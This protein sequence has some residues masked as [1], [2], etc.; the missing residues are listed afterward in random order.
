MDIYYCYHLINLF[1]KYRCYG[2]SEWTTGYHMQLK[3]TAYVASTTVIA[4]QSYSFK[5]FTSEL[6]LASYENCT[7]DEVSF[8][9]IEFRHLRF[10]RCRFERCKFVNVDATNI[11]FTETMLANSVFSGT[12]LCDQDF[13]GSTIENSTFIHN[14]SRCAIESEPNGDV[15]KLALENCLSKMAALPAAGVYVMAVDWVGRS[16]L[17]G[18]NH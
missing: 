17:L 13:R 12:D 6:I 4:N 16:K 5:T 7:F 10:Y 1:S 9:N 8:K 14:R 2:I 15:G 11:S 18:M 3:H